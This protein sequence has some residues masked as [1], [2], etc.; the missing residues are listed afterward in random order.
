MTEMPPRRRGHRWIPGDGGEIT[1]YVPETD[2]LHVLNATAFAIWELC[3]GETDVEEMAAAVSDATGLP[4]DV[5]R[6]E[7]SAALELLGRAGLIET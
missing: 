7:V 3:D 2:S 6:S 4:A 5:A 1:I